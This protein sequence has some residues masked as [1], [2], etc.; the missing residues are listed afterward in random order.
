MD[1]LTAREPHKS[2]AYLTKVKT[3]EQE[4]EASRNTCLCIMESWDRLAAYEDTGYTP[5]DV[6][7]LAAELLEYRATG[8]VDEC[9]TRKAG[10]EE[11]DI[12]HRDFEHSQDPKYAK[13][14]ALTEKR[15]QLA[16]ELL[17]AR[18]ENE[19]LTSIVQ[20]E[21]P[22]LKRAV[23]EFEPMHR[24]LCGLL[25]RTVMEK[26]ALTAERDKL[27]EENTRQYHTLLDARQEQTATQNH[28]YKTIAECKALKA[29]LDRYR[30]TGFE[31]GKVLELHGKY[32]ELYN[33]VFDSQLREIRALKA[34]RDGLA[35]I[36]DG[37]AFQLGQAHDQ[38]QGDLLT[39]GTLKAELREAQELAK[40]ITRCAKYKAGCWEVFILSKFMD[41]LRKLA[42]DAPTS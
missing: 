42:G 33:T 21:M 10:C 11:C 17:E 3:D 1:R 20:K 16:A 39:I 22:E 19:R 41:R 23:N 8:T 25:D 34:E 15:D 37:Q 4:I 28:L 40:I 31:P 6:A 24:E 7:K 30:N 35:R 14:A 29:E 18:A 38:A 36:I 2:M 12:A 32:K 26:S 27:Q 5:E 13:F 9:E